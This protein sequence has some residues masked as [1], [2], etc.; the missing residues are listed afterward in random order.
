MGEED[1][2]EMVHVLDA[3]RVRVVVQLVIIRA[4]NRAD[5]ATA[6]RS[7]VSASVRDSTLTLSLRSPILDRAR[8]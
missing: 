1:I 6:R 3:E 5:G 7:D 8:R 4:D 2:E